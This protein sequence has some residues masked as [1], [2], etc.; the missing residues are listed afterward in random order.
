MEL[1]WPKNLNWAASMFTSVFYIPSRRPLKDPNFHLMRYYYIISPEKTNPTLHFGQQISSINSLL[2]VGATTFLKLEVPT[3]I[4]SSLPRGVWWAN[5][6]KLNSSKLETNPNMG[7]GNLFFLVLVT[8]SVALITYNIILS[9]NAPLKQELP[10][11]SRS[12]SSITVDPVIKMPLDRSETSS[13]KRLFHTAVTASDSVYNTWQCRIMYY[14]FK[15][16]KD[17]PNSEMGGFTRILHSGKPDKYMDEIPTFVAQPLPAG[18][19]RVLISLV[20]FYYLR[21]WLLSVGLFLLL[22]FYYKLWES[23]GKCSSLILLCA[24]CGFIY[25]LHLFEGIR[26][27]KARGRSEFLLWQTP[28]LMKWRPMG[29]VSNWI[30]NFLSCF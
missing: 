26:L 12:S 19:D 10:G 15:K 17:G 1:Q 5:S 23:Q 14:W 28:W 4:L 11:P 13:S 30:Q 2:G 24:I 27:R 16:F 29:D 3:F 8:F 22:V 25:A 7:C 6:F 20:D 9:A 18:M 21:G